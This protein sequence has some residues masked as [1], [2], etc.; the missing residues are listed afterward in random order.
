C[1]RGPRG[2]AFGR[3]AAL[4]RSAPSLNLARE[5]L[6]PR[7][8][9]SSNLVREVPRLDELD[10][11][12]LVLLRAALGRLHDDL[13]PE[14]LAD[15]RARHR[16]GPRDLAGLEV[17]LVE[18]DDLVGRVLFGLLVL[19]G[20]GGAEDDALPREGGRIDDLGEG[21]PGLDLLDPPFD[22]ALLLLR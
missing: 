7:P 15:H 1:P 10:P 13:V 9:G 11:D 14:L 6:E 16:R 17:R 5:G 22:E 19:Q 21:E 12:D 3:C 8:R 20:D 4:R 18:P 2:R